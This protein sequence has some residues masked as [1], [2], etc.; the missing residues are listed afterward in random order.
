MKKLTEQ[1]A[2]QKLGQHYQDIATLTMSKRLAVETSLFDSFSAKC[3]GITLDYSR[4]RINQDTLSLLIDLA[5]SM[6]LKEKISALMTGSPVNFT[7]KRPALHTALRC[8]LPSAALISS[9]EAL[10]KLAEDVHSDLCKGITGK[11]FTTIV[12]IGIGGSYLGPKMCT[13]SLKDF[14]VAPLDFH[15]MSTVDADHVQDILQAVNPETTLFI[16]SSKSFTTI[17]TLTNAK[18]VRAWLTE[19]LGAKAYACHM[20]AV[21]ACPDKARALG[22]T[23]QNIFTFWE[24]VGG[25]YSIWSAIGLPLILLL[26][27]EQF[28]SFLHGAH[29]ID[30]HF[31]TAPFEKNL[32]VILALLGIWYTHFFGATALGIVPYSY[33]LRSFTAYIQ[34]L[35]MES[36]GKSITKN[37]QHIHHATGPVIFGEEGCNS[38]HSF[39]QS[40]HQSP[41]LIPIDSII[42]AKSNS[43][44]TPIHHDI[45]LAS[46][47]S[48]AFAFTHGKTVNEAYNDLIA[49]GTTPSEAASLAEHLAISGNKPNNLIILDRLSPENLGALIALYEHKI[50]VQGVLW[51]INSF[52]QWGVELGKTNLPIILKQMSEKNVAHFPDTAT[53]HLINHFNK[54]K[55]GE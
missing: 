27:K 6:D 14:A 41:H 52:D 11:P 39:Y 10:F 30:Q 13:E 22:F 54:M 15:F 50:Y 49:K 9:Q 16:V 45:M 53:T 8:P 37:G 36:N 19:K 28:K 18:T 17:E 20:L 42:V 32:P 29:T 55:D 44:M 33:R 25:R 23:D 3:N 47:L 24:W 46:A 21:T 1:P 43:Q 26:G 2:F 4:N 31:Q 38:Q 51:N 48:Q 7:E 5:N 40:L 35:D 34:Q 12:N